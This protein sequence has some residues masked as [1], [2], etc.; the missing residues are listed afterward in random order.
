[1]RGRNVLV[2]GAAI[3]CAG[4]IGWPVA[5]ASTA[6]APCQPGMAVPCSAPPLGC[7]PGTVLDPIQPTP[8]KGTLC[9]LTGVVVVRGKVQVLTPDQLAKLC[10]DL[11]VRNLV[12]TRVSVGNT[13]D[14][15]VTLDGRECT[16]TGD[17]VT[18]ATTVPAA[19]VAPVTTEAQPPEVQQTHLPV[20][21]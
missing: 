19:P 8:D 9:D 5:S 18:P 1:M 2:A 13:G 16:Y 15:I 11:H 20:T 17:T 7:P 12:K 3:V 21:G 10:Y 6:P 4:A 14:Q